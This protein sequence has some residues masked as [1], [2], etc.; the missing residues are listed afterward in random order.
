MKTES[1][2][3]VRCKVDI[4]TWFNKELNK[5]EMKITSPSGKTITIKK[6]VIEMN[7]SQLEKVLLTIIG[8]C[9]DGTALLTVGQMNILL[10]IFHKQLQV[11]K[12]KSNQ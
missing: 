1:A 7:L 11:S 4:S 5:A 12:V 2:K 9:K 6:T 10:D 8:E 3:I